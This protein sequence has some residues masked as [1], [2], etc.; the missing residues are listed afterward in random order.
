M[1]K[2]ENVYLKKTSKY[3]CQ[4]QIQM[5]LAKVHR[6]DFFVFQDAEHFLIFSVDLDQVFCNSVVE[7]AVYFFKSYVLPHIAQ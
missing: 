3:F 7:R 5:M 1:S 4:V 2:D 6:S